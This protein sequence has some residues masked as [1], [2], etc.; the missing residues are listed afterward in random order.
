MHLE[1]RLNYIDKRKQERSVNILP[2]CRLFTTK[3]ALIEPI[4]NSG[5]RSKNKT[6]TVAL[7]GYLNL[8]LK[9]SSP[10]REN[11]RM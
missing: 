11:F 7:N 5:I 10:D 8:F 9:F 3:S 1:E 2:H 6:G 4:L